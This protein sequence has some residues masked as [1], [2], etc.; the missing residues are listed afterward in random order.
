MILGDDKIGLALVKV[1]PGLGWE[2]A[3]PTDILDS[4]E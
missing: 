3:M 4:Y 1:G 2:Q